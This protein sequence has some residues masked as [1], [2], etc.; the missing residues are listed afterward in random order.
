[1]WGVV[2]NGVE[3]FP[4]AAEALGRFR[5]RG[6]T[7]VLI[8]N[9][10]RPAGPIIRQLDELGAP[11]DAYDA[12]VTSGDVTLALMAERGAAPVHH[13]GPARNL[14]LFEELAA[15]TSLV[16]PRVHLA[17][18]AYV[19]CTGLFD[20]EAET[21]E[22]Y[23]AAFAEM[24]AR[25]MPMVCANPDLVVHRGE[26][27]LPCAGALATRFE[28]MGGSV[29]YAGKPHPPIYA[30]ALGLAARA[31]GE[32]VDRARV[33][34]IGDAIRTDIAGAARLGIDTLFV[35][36][37]IH[38]DEFAHPELGLDLVRYRRFAAEAAHRP[39]VAIL[40]L[41]W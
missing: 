17:D 14:S 36:N 31:R 11:R 22:D 37:G 13:I 1:M 25:E 40:E 20:D 9:A 32:P 41:V 28:S 12:I 29:I 7:V 10:P 2:H 27:L 35:T 19:L 26:R 8:T 15:T 38:R 6:G 4:Q 30:Q 18:A 33:L 34:A 3:L 21:P 39:R 23:D 16:P 5:A 24:A